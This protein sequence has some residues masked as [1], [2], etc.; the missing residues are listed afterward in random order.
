MRAKLNWQAGTRDD[1]TEYAKYIFN[2]NDNK[3]YILSNWKLRFKSNTVYLKDTD[4]NPNPSFYTITAE[5]N[6]SLSS[7]SINIDWNTITLKI[8]DFNEINPWNSL[9]IGSKEK[10]KNYNIWWAIDYFKIYK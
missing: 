6:K 4:I 1:G 10:R 8:K 3:L 9:F 5:F 7:N 2:L